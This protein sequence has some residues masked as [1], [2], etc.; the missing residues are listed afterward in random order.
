MT[1][2]I[3]DQFEAFLQRITL[4]DGEKLNALE[5]G[6]RLSRRIEQRPEVRE[7]LITGSMVRSTAIRKF[8]D[9]DIVAVIE[10][11]DQLVRSEP[12]TLVST[13]AQML[14]EM[15]SDVQVSE[16]AVRV[17][18]IDDR[19]VDVLASIHLG[20]NSEGDH[21][22]RIPTAHREGWE[23][24]APEAQNRR[25][26]EATALLGE[27]FKRLIRLCKWWNKTHGQPISSHEIELFAY[28]TFHQAIPEL[29]LA[30]VHFSDFC[31]RH[32][33]GSPLTQARLLEF[34]RLAQDA[35]TK[36][37][38]GDIQKSSELW[39]RVFGDE[40]TAVIA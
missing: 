26:R 20:I 28:E 2:Q 6:Q 23:V 39:G 18:Y 32:I 38:S 33:D 36:Q 25:I 40:F 4:S 24:Y 1:D 35:Y 16:N 30:V 37:T 10:P 14:R 21:E 17:T 3:T 29:P 8:S 11:N 12:A 22:Y 13:V 7:C 31:R 15:E 5:Q 9:V 27:D 19:A 34:N